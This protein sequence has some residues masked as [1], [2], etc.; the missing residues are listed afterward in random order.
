[1]YYFTATIDAKESNVAALTISTAL[2]LIGAI[3]GTAKVG[4]TLTAGAVDPH[5]IA[6]ART[7][8]IDKNFFRI[9]ALPYRFFQLHSIESL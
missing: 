7:K 8:I 9:L 2:T 3:S 1:M 6:S 4:N 5:E